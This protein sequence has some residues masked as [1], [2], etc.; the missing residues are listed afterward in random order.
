MLPIA[1]LTK[2]TRFELL[3]HD[4]GEVAITKD[5]FIFGNG[6]CVESTVTCFLSHD[7]EQRDGKKPATDP[8]IDQ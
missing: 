6:I 3:H 8:D 5:T 2:T 4:R 1:F 7:M